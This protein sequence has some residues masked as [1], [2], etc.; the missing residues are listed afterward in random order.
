MKNKL[1]VITG[2]TRGI[3]YGL[4]K[5]FL[6]SG[7]SV[8]ISGRSQETVEKAVANLGS[9][10]EAERVIGLAC[11]VTVPVQVQELWDRSV[12]KFGKVD[13]W[14][15]NAGDS[16]EQGLVWDLSPDDA[17]VPINANILGTVYGAQVAMKGMLSQGFGAIYNMEGMG[18][19]GR[20]HAGLTI[21]GTSKYAI[22]YFTESLALEAKQTPVIVGALRPGMVITV[23]PGVYFPGRGGVRIEDDILVTDTGAEVLS[24]LPRALD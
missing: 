18:S 1:I 5:A 10:F 16:G 13:I 4:A 20:K 17:Q 8:S 12:E 22:H 15:N 9:K 11:D 2:T 14:I 21:Y 6:S 23:E 19:D 24:S 7:H 3:G